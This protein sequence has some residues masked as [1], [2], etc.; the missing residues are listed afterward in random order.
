MIPE[1]RMQ[2]QIA[3]TTHYGEVLRTTLF[4]QLGISAMIG[5]GAEGIILPLFV[6]TIAITVFGVAAG[7]AA[8]DDIGALRN[9]MD[10]EMAGSN[11]AKF[12]RGRNL[13]GLKMLSTGL[14]VLI[15]ITEL[16]ALLF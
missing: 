10:E 1:L 16:L 3:R 2:L 11:Y 13:E 15:G 9:D 7:N 5:F 12:A 4:G 8:L 14:L 6:M